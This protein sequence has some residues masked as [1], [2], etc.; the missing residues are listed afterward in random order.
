[1]SSILVIGAGRVGATI[2]HCLLASQHPYDIRLL[3]IKKKECEGELFDLQDTVSTTKAGTIHMGSYKDAKNAD[4]IIITAGSARIPKGGSR[5]DLLEINKKIITSIAKKCGKL[6]S[7]A[8]VIMVTN[9][10]DVLT[11][12]AKDVFKLPSPQ[13]MGTG[14]LLDSARMKTLL[15]SELG[16]SPR[17]I[18][19]YVLGEHGQSSF[20]AWSSVMVE[21]AP[22]SSHKRVTKR[23]KSKI[24]KDVR[25]RALEIIKRK[26][27]TYYGIAMI[28]KQLVNA[29]YTDAQITLPVSTYI[30]SWNGTKAVSIGVPCRIG[31]H[32]VEALSPLK[33]S[34]GEKKQL[35][36]SAA[37]LKKAAKG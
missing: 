26:G 11:L 2:A 27:G 10:V 30:K 5:L 13:V 34:P 28:T 33:L 15:A 18:S 9:P 6:K 12:H 19:G 16:I 3:D 8:I 24:E 21:G 23:L 17:D 31:A 14:T 29:I 20:V 35:R 1:M 22:V 25:A 4:I 7:T 32:G 37:I 36:K